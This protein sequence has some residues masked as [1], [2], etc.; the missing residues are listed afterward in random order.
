MCR[1]LL[2][3]V[4]FLSNYVNK[5]CQ[6][7]VFDV[8]F[9]QAELTFLLSILRLRAMFPL[10]WRRDWEEE[11][12]DEACDFFPRKNW[13]SM[14]V[15]H[16]KAFIYRSTLGMCA[17]YLFA[18]SLSG[19]CLFLTQ[20]DLRN[21]GLDNVLAF[22]IALRCVAMLCFYNFEQ[23]SVFFCLLLCYLFKMNS[24]R[25]HQVLLILL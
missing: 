2:S 15:T 19:C 14:S 4:Y 3:S 23:F 13:P 9:R 24:I 7:I 22:F 5:N 10:K 8:S 16:L 21:C 20:C 17:H 12:N 6:S 11:K 1:F 18:W 25:C